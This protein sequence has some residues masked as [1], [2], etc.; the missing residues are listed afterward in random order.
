MKNYFLFSIRTVLL[1]TLCFVFLFS[2]EEPEEAVVPDTTVTSVNIPD[3]VKAQFLRLGFDPSDL[4][5]QGE[6][7][8]IE[9]D[10]VVS[11]E[12]LNE[13]LSSEPNTASG[14][15]GEQWRYS[16]GIVSHHMKTI[17]ISPTDNG[18]RFLRG[19]DRAIHN[20]NSL[21][22]LS[23]EMVRV[24]VGAP[25]DIIISR[26][27]SR[28]GDPHGSA[29]LPRRGRPGYRIKIYSDVFN[30][31]DNYIEGVITHELGHAVGLRHS[32]P[33]SRELK[34]S[35]LIPNTPRYDPLSIMSGTGISASHDGEFS[36]YDR[37]AI[38]I[39]Y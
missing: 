37:R 22:L 25:S 11:P 18:I 30:Y 4:I 7:Y 35:V 31:S 16:K 21:S 26:F 5:M 34:T 12:T 20:F 23:F 24:P 17:R 32:N 19:I 6:D 3:E 27:A 2:C 15:E 28:K 36:K 14:P 13:M 10:I 29:Q 1:A 38:Q 8:W 9:G 39:I 33:T